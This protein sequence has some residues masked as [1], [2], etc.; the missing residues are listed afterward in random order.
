[1]SQYS[2]KQQ[3]ILKATLKPEMLKM[4]E[5]ELLPYKPPTSQPVAGQTTNRT[6]N[7]AQN[8][9]YNNMTW[10]QIQGTKKQVDEQLKALERGTPEYNQVKQQQRALDEITKNTQKQAQDKLRGSYST[11]SKAKQYLDQDQQ[12]NTQIGKLK[13]DYMS[14]FLSG[15]PQIRTQENQALEQAMFQAQSGQQ[16]DP[17]YQALMAQ[18]NPL[19]GQKSSNADQMMQYALQGTTSPV[20]YGT[21]AQLDAAYPM[22]NQPPQQYQ[23]PQFQPFDF[24]KVLQ[25]YMAGNPQAGSIAPRFGPKQNPGV[26]PQG[27]PVANNAARINFISTPPPNNLPR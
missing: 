1:M 23:S 19:L 3:A 10:D 9:G 14:Q 17:K 18:I 27:S 20:G 2:A 5:R 6:M 8:L 4:M 12:Y 16:F 11:D 25:G 26:A 24:N 15:D 7:A 22:N 21:Q 13:G